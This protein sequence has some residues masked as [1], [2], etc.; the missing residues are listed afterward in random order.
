MRQEIKSTYGEN[1]RSKYYDPDD[2]NEDDAWGDVMRAKQ[3]IEKYDVKTHDDNNPRSMRRDDYRGGYG[4]YSSSNQRR[5][6]DG[7]NFDD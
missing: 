2:F 3:E 4:S 6:G 1:F 5:Y 7:P